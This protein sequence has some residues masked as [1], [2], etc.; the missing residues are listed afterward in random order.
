M[1][2]L[3]VK[4]YSNPYLTSVINSEN[5]SFLDGVKSFGDF[6]S[7]WHETGSFWITIYNKPFSQVM[8]EFF[9]ELGRDIGLFVL[10]NSDI[11]FLLPAIILMFGTF[12]IGKNKYTKW[13]IPLWFAYFVA[14]FFH[15]MLL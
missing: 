7:K 11:F 3:G 2:I 8:G 14:T 1:N 12:V 15:K 13:I 10:G 6:I 4:T 5:G 9:K